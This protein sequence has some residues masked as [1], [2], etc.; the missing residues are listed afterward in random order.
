V[1]EPVVAATAA[2]PVGGVN[3][4][5]IL[6]FRGVPYGAPTGGTR[7]FMPPAPPVPWTEV[8]ECVR[9]GLPSPQPPGGMGVP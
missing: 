2:G 6:L 7:R 1:S 5:G 8:R 3:R 9:Y 4:N